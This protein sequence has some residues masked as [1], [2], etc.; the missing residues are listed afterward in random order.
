MPADAFYGEHHQRIDRWRHRCLLLGLLLSGRRC[1]RLHQPQHRRLAVE[2]GPLQHTTGQSQRQ[3]H[4]P[5][6]EDLQVQPAADHELPAVVEPRGVGPACKRERSGWHDRRRRVVARSDRLEPGVV[7]VGNQHL[8]G[9]CEASRARQTTGLLGVIAGAVRIVGDDHRII[10][11]R[12]R[13]PRVERLQDVCNRQ[14]RCRLRRLLADDS[15]RGSNQQQPHH[16]AH[17]PRRCPPRQTMG[18]PSHGVDDRIAGEQHDRD[19]EARLEEVVQ[20]QASRQLNRDRSGQREHNAAHDDPP[21]SPP[22]ATSHRQP[23]GRHQHRDANGGKEQ[24][25]LLHQ[26]GREP[27]LAAQ[28]GKRHPAALVGKLDRQAPHPRKR[29]GKRLWRPLGDGCCRHEISVW[30]RGWLAQ[31]SLD[32]RL[33]L[34][35]LLGHNLI[36]RHLG[37]VDSR[38]QLRGCE[39]GQGVF[40]FQAACWLIGGDDRTAAREQERALGLRQEQ[41]E[42]RRVPSDTLDATTEL[43]EQLRRCDQRP[44]PRRLCGCKHAALAAD[45]TVAVG[46]HHLP[47]DIC[48]RHIKSRQTIFASHSKL[49]RFL[50]NLPHPIQ[51]SRRPLVD[52]R[53]VPQHVPSGLPRQADKQVVAIPLGQGGQAIDRHRPER[54]C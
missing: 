6:R 39:Q 31:R 15:D 46:E 33:I 26:H 51:A 2:R 5:F 21:A 44:G 30:R 19:Q 24:P 41:L 28:A 8:A 1:C 3:I 17:R 11:H 12:Q 18:H 20:L 14:S 42:Q 40:S 49:R 9:G 16:H 43:R 22:A 52:D 7:L 23:A 32:R 29:P 36:D 47:L 13:V 53:D 10:G 37:L 45:H 50:R 35:L 48:Q 25:A 27:W 4:G 34:R 54:R 38:R